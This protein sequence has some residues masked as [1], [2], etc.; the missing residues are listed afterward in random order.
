MKTVNSRYFHSN[1][2]EDKTSYDGSVALDRLHKYY[3][4]TILFN[5]M[6]RDICS[7]V[8][9]GDLRLSNIIEKRLE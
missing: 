4:K 7:K 9:L 3:C 6:I 8:C 5:A 1:N 2:I